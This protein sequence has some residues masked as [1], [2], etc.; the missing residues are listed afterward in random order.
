V[1]PARPTATGTRW[2]LP[3]SSKHLRPAGPPRGREWRRDGQAGPGRWPV[4][5]LPPPTAARL[6]V[7]F[8]YAHR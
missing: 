4:R 7:S 2:R 8:S 1:S 6:S 3:F 5:L